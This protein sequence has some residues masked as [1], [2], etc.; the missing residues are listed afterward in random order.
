MEIVAIF[1]SITTKTQ[2][3]MK[4]ILSFVAEHPLL[5]LLTVGV[6]LLAFRWGIMGFMP[7]MFVYLLW[8]NTIYGGEE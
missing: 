4:R 1:A 2:S 3:N 7:L 5:I 6:I 8:E